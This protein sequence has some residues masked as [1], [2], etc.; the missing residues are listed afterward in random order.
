MRG[1]AGTWI[2]AVSLLT[3][4]NNCEPTATAESGAWHEVQSFV[5]NKGNVTAIAISPDGDRIAVC[6]SMYVQG[7]GVQH[8]VSLCGRPGNQQFLKIGTHEGEIGAAAFAPDGATLATTGEDQTVKL[9]DVN[10]LKP[11]QSL[12]VGS[13]GYGVAFTPDGQRL[14]AAGKSLSVWSIPK[15]RRVVHIDGTLISSM[16]VSPESELVAT[17][18]QFPANRHSHVVRLR[19][20]ATG[21]ILQTLDEQH[22]RPIWSLA[23]SAD[24]RRLV[25]GSWDGTA[26]IWDIAS[27]KSSLALSPGIGTIFSV[28]FSPDGSLIS[29]GNWDHPLQLWSTDTG[30]HKLTLSGGR[31][32]CAAFSADGEI[33]VTNGAPKPAP[34]R[35]PLAEVKVWRFVE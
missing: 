2:V 10:L 5:S 19:S 31:G 24:G 30:Q 8:V 35:A 34:D 18:E 7:V 13:R 17:G 16:A 23:F 6:A 15:L 20:P 9:W 14:I 3:T 21:E 28:A 26:R 1:P 33:L 12:P 29:I 4:A 27:G 11:I 32:R 22:T 25:S